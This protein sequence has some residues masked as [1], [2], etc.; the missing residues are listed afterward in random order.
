MSGNIQTISLGEITHKGIRYDLYADLLNC[1]PIGEMDPKRLKDITAVA[2]GLLEEHTAGKENSSLEG[3]TIRLSDAGAEIA[4]VLQTHASL[5]D[6]AL[7]SG[8]L[9]VEAIW[10]SVKGDLLQ[11]VNAK[12]RNRFR[13]YYNQIHKAAD[14]QKEM[15]KLIERLR[16]EKNERDAN[17]M[18]DIKREYIRSKKLHQSF[19]KH[20]KI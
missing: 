13:L 15:E 2:L 3:K 16:K 17:V 5:P 9:K 6:V 11:H 14:P 20:I 7:S 8:T 10:K 18:E 12:S 4:G 19:N 1:P